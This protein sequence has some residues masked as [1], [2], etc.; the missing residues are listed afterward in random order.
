MFPTIDHATAGPH[1]VTGT[2]VKLSETPGGPGF[3]APLQ[4]EHTREVMKE[5]F[6]LDDRALDDLEARRVIFE[7]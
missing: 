3:A 6:G 1:R 4:G 2:P 5:F 7:A